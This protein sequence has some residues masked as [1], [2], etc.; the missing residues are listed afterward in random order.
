MHVERAARQRV[1]QIE[2]E[3]AACLRLDIHVLLEEAPGAASVGL[4]AVE[5]HVGI[6]QERVGI[7]AVARRDSD[8]DAR[9]PPKSAGSAPP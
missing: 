4:G 3:I 2:L 8:A 7:D 6:L 1:A 9:Y 5:R